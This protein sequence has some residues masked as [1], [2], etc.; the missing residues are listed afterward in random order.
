[1]KP[2]KSRTV[3]KIFMGI[4]IF[5]FLVTVAAAILWIFSAK[6]S[7]PFAVKYDYFMAA[8]GITLILLVITLW[9]F[10]LSRTRKTEDVAY[11]DETDT[12]AQEDA[13]ADCFAEPYTA[14]QRAVMKALA[15]RRAQEKAR[16]AKLKDAAKIVGSIAG[17]FALGIA[18]AVMIRKNQRN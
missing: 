2:K 15:A 18:V 6:I 13:V 12:E 5:S 8:L 17:G 11:T 14:Q 1:M 9:M 3:A 10:V 7:L 16:E 4:T